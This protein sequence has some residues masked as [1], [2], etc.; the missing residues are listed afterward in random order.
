MASYCST[1]VSN[2]LGAGCPRTARLAVFV[3]VLLAVIDGSVIST[4]IYAIR[5]LLGHAYSSDEEVIQ[6]VV[7]M[8]PLVSA[9]AFMDAIQGVLSGVVRGCGQQDLGAYVNLGAFY[10]LGVPL[11]CVLGFYFHFGGIGLWIGILSGSTAQAVLLSLITG[12]TNWQRQED[13]APAEWGSTGSR[14]S[15]SSWVGD[16][17]WGSGMR[18]MRRQGVIALPL[19]LVT[20]FQFLLQIV[21][22]MM[23]GHLSSLSLSSAAIA[24]SLCNVT[25]YIILLGMASAFETLCGQAYGAEQYQKLG[26]YTQTAIIA[27]LV[28][29]I[30]ITILWFYMEKLL[31]L[32]GQDSDISHEAGKYALCLLPGLFGFALLQP[33][34]KFL[35]SQ[36]L[37]LPL[38]GASAFTLCFHVPVCWLL[39]FKSSVG[40]VGAAVAV[41]LS[42]WVNVAALALYI[43]FA[44]ACR[45]TCTR[46]SKE[47]ITGIH[48]FVGL[49]LLSACWSFELLVLVSGL[50]PDPELEASV[51]SIWYGF[52]VLSFIDKLST[53]VSNELGGGCPRTARLAV[54]VA[55]MLA[56]I[57]GSVISTSIY[58]VRYL[59]GH[60]YSSDEEVIRYV[61]KMAPLVSVSAFMDAIQGVLSERLLGRKEDAASE[62]WGSTGS[63]NSG[64]SWVGDGWWGSGMREMRRQGVIALP[65][66]LV[67]MFQFLLQIVSLMMVGHLS[68]LSLSSAA[69]ASSLCNVTGYIILLCLESIQLV[70]TA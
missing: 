40:Y 43:K 45:K 48:N 44:P 41:S 5:Y 52:S 12:F 54:V 39:L 30:P 49:A 38:L 33:M 21:S 50:L 23:V 26:L 60:A 67:T 29:C 8:A 1:R 15:G 22:L 62:E 42:Y 46:F 57:D 55:V 19:V 17:W 31:I 69:I 63:K 35:Q 3:A 7:K 61:V 4:S 68:S 65:L 14:N 11:A 36:S 58:A 10:L 25:G 47:A 34:A 32:I 24:S 2:E 64:S 53:R 13:A 28:V 56:V 51:L 59:L 6:Y 9:S 37:V 27:L 16:G 18:E 20:M 70:T 66:V